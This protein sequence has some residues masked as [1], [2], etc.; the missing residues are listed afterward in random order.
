VA[1]HTHEFK[2]EDAEQ[3]LL[4]LGKETRSTRVPICI[5]L[6]PSAATMTM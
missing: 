2:L 1:L 6:H 4:T 3:A 5:T